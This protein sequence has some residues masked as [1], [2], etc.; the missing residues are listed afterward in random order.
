MTFTLK[1]LY[2]LVDKPVPIIFGESVIIKGSD[3]Y[4]H[5]NRDNRDNRDNQDN[6]DNRDDTP[7]FKY[8]VTF[9]YEV[10]RPDRYKIKTYIYDNDIFLMYDNPMNPTNRHIPL[11]IDDPTHEP[12]LLLWELLTRQE[13]K[14]TTAEKSPI[15]NINSRYHQRF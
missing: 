12:A 11:N 2:Q 10:T 3:Y 4:I 7:S 6:R 5:G 8:G 1:Y 13:V 15:S 9:E 14:L